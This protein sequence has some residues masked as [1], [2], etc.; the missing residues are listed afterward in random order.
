MKRTLL[1]GI[2]IG[3]QST[4]S[5]L[6]TLDGE[7]VASAGRSQEMETPQAGRPIHVIYHSG[8]GAYS[9][10][11]S[12]IKAD[13]YQKPVVTSE[14]TEGGLLGAAILAGSGAGVD[15]SEGEGVRGAPLHQTRRWLSAMI[16]SSHCSRNFTIGSRRRSS[17]WRK[18]PE[19]LAC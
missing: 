14:N 2:D 13:I 19:H 5:A 9:D 11:W 8:G 16:I 15:A 6:L 7:V 4:R 1:M 18:C 17:G 10:L 12:Q 3:A